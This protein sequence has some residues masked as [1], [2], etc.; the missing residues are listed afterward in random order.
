MIANGDADKKIWITE[1]GAPTGGPGPSATVENSETATNTWHVDEPLQAKML[2]EAV[3]LYKSYDWV[4]PFFWY[5]YKDAGTS[6]DSNENFFGLV[7]ADG[8]HKPAY[9]TYK[10]SMR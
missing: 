2:Q 1:Y 8:S 5:S 4:G 9:D 7:R 6:Q 3:K 10:Q